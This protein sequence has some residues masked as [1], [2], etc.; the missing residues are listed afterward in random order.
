[1]KI[2]SNS[3]EQHCNL[4]LN[5]FWILYN[6]DHPRNYL[7]KENNLQYL[8][9]VIHDEIAFVSF[10]SA[11]YEYGYVDG[12]EIIKDFRQLVISPMYT[13]QWD[14]SESV[15]RWEVHRTKSWNKLSFINALANKF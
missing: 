3:N 15:Y 9:A 13:V 8:S 1:M 12:K 10:T 14:Q 2:E 6:S 5:C 7:Q 4:R 11:P